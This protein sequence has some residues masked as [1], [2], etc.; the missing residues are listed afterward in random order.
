MVKKFFVLWGAG[1]VATVLALPYIFTLQRSVIEKAGQPLWLLGLVSVVQAGILLAVSVFFGLR[2]IKKIN[3]NPFVFFDSTVPV[4][5][6]LKRIAKLCVPVGI[7][8]ALIIRFGDFFFLK[9]IPELKVASEA[10]PFWKALSVAPYGGVVEELLMRLFLVSLFAWIFG[11]IFKSTEVIKNNWIMWAS[12]IVVAVI[13]GLGHLPATATI[14]ALTPIVIVRA[15]LLNGI[16]GIFFGWLY[17][18]KG[19]EYAIVAHFTADIVLHAILPTL[20]K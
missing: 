12:I 5:E 14:V 6:N 15:I 10:I 1:V 8:V 20:L 4:K 13:F 2:L 19:L 16:G 11:K 18:K 7:L 17:W 3:L 9:S